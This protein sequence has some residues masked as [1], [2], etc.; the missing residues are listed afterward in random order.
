MISSLVKVANDEKNP[1]EFLLEG[2]FE[3]ALIAYKNLKELNPTHPMVTEYYIN[4]IAYDFYH[5]DRMALSLNTFKVNMALYPDSYEVYDSYAE[6]CM[7][8]GNI[9]L[10][11][12]NYTKSLE[13]NPQNNGAKH[14]LMELKK[15][16]EMNF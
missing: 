16:N 14:K 3:N 13:L 7:K 15:A 5:A 4:D 10:A 2:D 12:A 8:V 11:I 9:D 6:A 1:V